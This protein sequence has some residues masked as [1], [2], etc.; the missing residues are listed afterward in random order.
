M[1]VLV[2][3]ATGFVGRGLVPR[4]VAANHDVRAVSRADH[5]DLAAPIDWTPFLENVDA[6]VHLAG[7]AHATSKLPDEHYD[8]VNHR[9]TADLACASHAAGVRRFVFV[10]SIRAQ[11][12]AVATHVLDEASPPA[13]ADAY[14]RSKL[15]AETAI[16]AI[17]IA[18]TILRPVLVYGP[19]LKGNLATLRGLA[20]R[21][22]PLPFGAFHNRRSLLALSGLS[23]AIELAL[24]APATKDQTFVVADR[25]PVELREIIAA[26]RKGAGRRPG[27]VSV[28]LVVMRPALRLARMWD[29]VGGELVVDPA[30]L[31]A[32]GWTPIADTAAELARLATR[33]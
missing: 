8:R 16:R 10:S 14:G 28:P 32:A 2:T 19:D 25:T 13:P 6:V 9:A 24:S 11:T 17:G 27:L 33:E 15:A 26:F 30:K 7:Q 21:R 29:R 5:G 4:L 23:S 12:G 31:V 20:S 1:R 3:G 18:H 22:I